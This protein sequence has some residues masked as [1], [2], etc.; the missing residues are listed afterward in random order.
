MEREKEKRANSLLLGTRAALIAAFIVPRTPLLSPLLSPSIPPT[1][2]HPLATLHLSHF[3]APF[4]LRC[5][6]SFLFTS[7]HSHDHRTLPFSPSRLS[8]RCFLDSLCRARASH[9]RIC[10]RARGSL[11]LP[12]P[13]YSG[14]FASCVFVTPSFH[15][16]RHVSYASRTFVRARIFLRPSPSRS[17][18]LNPFVSSASLSFISIQS[19]PRITCTLSYMCRNQ[20]FIVFVESLI[21]GWRATF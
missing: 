8:P 2:R 15:L 13:V 17:T 4:Q 20:R 11:W 6:S 7:I 9:I 1:Y 10:S 16:I 18:I 21:L 19:L 3:L 12:A 14:S 5:H